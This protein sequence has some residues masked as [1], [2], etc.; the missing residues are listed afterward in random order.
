MKPDEYLYRVKVRLQN[1]PE[2]LVFFECK[3]M[4][5]AELTANN[6]KLNPHATDIKI[7]VYELVN[8]NNIFF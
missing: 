5:L 4:A 6:L 7:E 2:H 3:D 8:I 1:T